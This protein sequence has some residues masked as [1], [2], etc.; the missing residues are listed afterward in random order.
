MNYLALSAWEIA[1]KIKNKEISSTQVTKLSL[2]RAKSMNE[3][4]NGYITICEEEAL[5]KAAEV[6]AKIAAGHEV[7]PLAGVPY[8]MKDNICTKNILTT[9][10][11]KMLYN[12]IPPYDAFVTKKLDEADCVLTQKSLE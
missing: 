10:A 9:C 6:D 12:F 2:E 1:E 3:T 11:S 7:S 5:K 8:A 4:I